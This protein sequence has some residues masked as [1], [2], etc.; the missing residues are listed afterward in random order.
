MGVSS[1]RGSRSSQAAPRVMAAA[2]E[3]APGTISEHSRVSS[4]KTP[5]HPCPRWQVTASPCAQTTG[6]ILAGKPANEGASLGC[7][8]MSWSR[9]AVGR[10]AQG[11]RHGGRETQSSFQRKMRGSQLTLK[12]QDLSQSKELAPSRLFHCRHT[13]EAGTHSAR[14]PG[15]TPPH[16]QE[17]ARPHAAAERAGSSVS[18]QAEQAQ[19][20][21]VYPGLYPPLP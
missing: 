4:S 13:G 10:A 9:W 21:P 8:A 15:E 17:A 6:V 14:L 5:P 1:P 7:A 12:M 16:L 20:Q 18:S 11:A 3:P 19:Q 2:Q